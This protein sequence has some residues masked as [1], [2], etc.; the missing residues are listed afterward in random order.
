MNE[1]ILAVKYSKA[2]IKDVF[3]G[4]KTKYGQK[5][6]TF[7]SSPQTMNF[8][9]TKGEIIKQKT[10]QT[11]PD[12][13]FSKRPRTKGQ[14]LKDVI[15][16][17]TWQPK[18]SK[19]KFIAVGVNKDETT[20]AERTGYYVA[21]A[22]RRKGKGGNYINFKYSKKQTKKEALRKAYKETWGNGS[23]PTAEYINKILLPELNKNGA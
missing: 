4:L 8:L 1:P 23:K 13:S 18:N 7:L 14:H 16:I 6:D 5:L 15:K 2:E 21:I 20:K 19:M 11:V 10:Q 17:W 9:K 3:D 22:G 12:S